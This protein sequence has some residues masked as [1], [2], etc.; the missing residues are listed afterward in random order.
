VCLTRLVVPSF[1]LAHHMQRK[2]ERH[3]FVLLAHIT[4]IAVESTR[5]AVSAFGLEKKKKKKKK[6][7]K[8]PALFLRYF[9]SF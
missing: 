4:T 3:G 2:N 9:G 7:S 6:K 8:K 1:L 5:R